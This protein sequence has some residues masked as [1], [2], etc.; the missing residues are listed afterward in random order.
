MQIELGVPRDIDISMNPALDD[1]LPVPL[2]TI[3]S[4]ALMRLS[5]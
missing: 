5:R 2:S 1:E 3:V 4:N